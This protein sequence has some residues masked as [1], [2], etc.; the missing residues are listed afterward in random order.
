VL[1]KRDK[2]RIISIKMSGYKTVDKELDPDGKTMP[3]SL[4]LEK[5]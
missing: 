4:V 2:P 5:E 3:I 1:I